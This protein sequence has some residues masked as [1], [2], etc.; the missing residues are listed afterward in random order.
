MEALLHTE[1]GSEE[2]GRHVPWM[3]PQNAVQWEHC[4][5]QNEKGRWEPDFDHQRMQ[6]CWSIT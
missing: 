2:G 4:W 6:N 1:L 3:G 5:V